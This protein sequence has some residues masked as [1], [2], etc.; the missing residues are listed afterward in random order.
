MIISFKELK[1]DFNSRSKNFTNKKLYI[2]DEL[3]QIEDFLN[4]KQFEVRTGSVFR[5]PLSEYKPKLSLLK[6]V[7]S[8]VK[9]Y[10]SFFNNSYEHYLYNEKEKSFTPV[11]KG[12]DTTQEQ[13]DDFN[14]IVQEH[15]FQGIEFAKY[16]LWLKRN[17][18]GTNL[19]SKKSTLTLNQKMLALYYLGVDMRDYQN[20]LQASKILAQILGMDWTN[21]KESL[22]Y[23]DG[24]N[25]KVKKTENI[26]KVLELF[27]NECFKPIQNKIREDLEK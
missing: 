1:E 10:W 7:F 18:R 22:T 4:Y 6:A 17:E 20:N 2:Q 14:K 24:K 9:Y 26:K 15:H 19:S 8:E 21:I 11:K 27:E 5:E 13:V 16:V 12:K 25:S 23:F 3:K